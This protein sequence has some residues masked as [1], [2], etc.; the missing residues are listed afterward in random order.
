MKKIEKNGVVGIG[1]G[2]GTGTGT[3]K[4]E[5]EENVRG[6]LQWRNYFEIAFHESSL[7]VQS[8]SMLVGS[9]L[10]DTGTTV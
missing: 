10:Q 5:E 7:S 1:I 8:K 3:G 9:I 4:E 2:T 6:W